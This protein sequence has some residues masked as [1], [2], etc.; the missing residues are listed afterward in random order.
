MQLMGGI[1]NFDSVTFPN[2]LNKYKS[3]Y[4]EARD[5]VSLV[6]KWFILFFIDK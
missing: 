1:K 4:F 6:S 3:A 2:L 5:N